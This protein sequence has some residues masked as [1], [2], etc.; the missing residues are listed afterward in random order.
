MLNSLLL[1]MNNIPHEGWVEVTRVAQHF[2]ETA[3]PLLS[4]VLSLPLN[5]DTLMLVV[6][7]PEYF[8]EQFE[9]FERGLII[10]FNQTKVRHER[11]SIK[12]IHNKFNILGAQIG[13]LRE[14]LSLRGGIS[15]D[16]LC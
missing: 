14:D 13:S 15:E 9:Q 2:Q 11:R 3:N 1:S 6:Q 5:I 4:F 8:V 7:M 12:A 10:E 16:A